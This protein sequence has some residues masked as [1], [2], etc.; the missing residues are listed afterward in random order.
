MSESERGD[1][2]LE[3]VSS[4]V[5]LGAPPRPVAWHEPSPFD[6]PSVVS[7]TPHPRPQPSAGAEAAQSPRIARGTDAGV[8]EK[9]PLPAPPSIGL[10][11]PRRGRLAHFVARLGRAF[12]RLRLALALS[13][14]R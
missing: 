6:D 14:R 3:V 7:S 9:L 2:E 8:H 5:T 11:R 12:A 13:R 4:T 10:A 1:E